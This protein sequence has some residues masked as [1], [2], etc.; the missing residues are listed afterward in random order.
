[1]VNFEEWKIYIGVIPGPFNE[2]WFFYNHNN[3]YPKCGTYGYNTYGSNQHV[4][5]GEVR[6]K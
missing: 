5:F 2:N 6:K 3:F 4:Q 1:M